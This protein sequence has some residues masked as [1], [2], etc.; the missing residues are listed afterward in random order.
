MVIISLKLTDNSIK[1][2]VEVLGNYYSLSYQKITEFIEDITEGFITIS[3]GTI[4][5]IYEEFSNKSEPTLNNIITNLLNGPYQHTDETTTSENGRETYYR[6]YANQTNVIYKYHKHKGDKPI[7]EDGIL[8]NYWGTIVS[9]H[10]HGIF[11]YGTNNQ[12]CIIHIGRHCKEKSQNIK[13]IEWPKTIFEF[14]LEIETK[15][16][17]LIKNGKNEFTESEIELIEKKYDNILEEGKIQ[18][19]KIKSKYWKEKTISLLNRLIKFKNNVL[20]YI[21]DFSIPYD[22][23]F[24]ERALRMIK[25]KTK[26]S[27]GFRSQEGAIRFGNTMSIIKTAK[28]RKINSFYCI[29]SVFEGKSLFA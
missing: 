23:N 12:D 28:L 19:R 21:H 4:D 14:L 29:K 9:D 25:G 8:N 17:E 24:M 5:N 13:N 22:N 2:L 6:G 27:G 20:F 1:V 3:E 15:R 11:K 7:K 18:N 16:K 26:M 10:E